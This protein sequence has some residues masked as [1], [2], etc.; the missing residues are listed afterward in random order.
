MKC[1]YNCYEN[2]SWQCEQERML[3]WM[4]G[5]M[6]YYNENYFNGSCSA[7]AKPIVETY[8]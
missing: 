1:L 4:G 7:G 8:L 2:T 3:R 6:K 5:L